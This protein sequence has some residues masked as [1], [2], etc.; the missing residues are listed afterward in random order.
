IIHTKNAPAP[1]GP[2]SQAVRAGNM[3]YVSGQIAID[4]ETDNLINGN[5]EDETK[6]VMKNIKELLSASGFSFSD[7]VK[8][9]IFLSDMEHFV[10]VNGIYG[11]YFQ[12]DFP[13]RETVAVLGL[14]KNVNV[15]ISVTAYKA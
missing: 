13:A 9:T 14:P 5:I 3:L 6:Q 10:L 4:P 2:Y 12:S 15:E 8:T 11:S 7:I 1:I